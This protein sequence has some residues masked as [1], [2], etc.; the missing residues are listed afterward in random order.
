MPQ[1]LVRFL[2]YFNFSL[3]C[4]TNIQHIYAPLVSMNTHQ[5]PSLPCE[6]KNFSLLRTQRWC[7]HSITTSQHCGAPAKIKW[8]K[9]R[10]NR[11]YVN[12]VFGYTSGEGKKTQ[13][14]FAVLVHALFV[15]LFFCSSAHSF[16]SSRRT[17]AASVVD[18]F[19]DARCTLKI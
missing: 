14:A 7:A 18:G 15:F 1:P 12:D 6:P 19:D 8:R 17:S 16:V 2:F 11:R 10:E 9:A 4:F 13:A 3:C 5:S